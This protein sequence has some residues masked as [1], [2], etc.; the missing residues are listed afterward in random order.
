[1]S[2]DAVTTIYEEIQAERDHQRRKWGGAEHDDQHTTF[3]WLAIL[4]KHVGQA[5]DPGERGR[6][7]IPKYRHQMIRV[8]AVAVAAI[9]W[10]DR[11][12][13]DDDA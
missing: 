3:D 10:C 8:A 4:T 9:E 7:D 2:D 13:G 1:M 5:F 12:F 6:L 11:N